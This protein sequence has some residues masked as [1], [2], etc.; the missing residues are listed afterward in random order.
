MALAPSKTKKIERLLQEGVMSKRAISR[1]EKVSRITI[2]RIEKRLSSP[3]ESSPTP[4][5]P[6]KYTR[7]KGCGGKVL[8]SIPCVVCQLQNTELNNYDT[9]M[10]E[11]LTPSPFQE[12]R[13][14]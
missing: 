6:E 12:R 11:L 14:A 5:D 3:Q 8:K 1:Q 4:E 10:R 2:D 9:Y 7:C 13:H